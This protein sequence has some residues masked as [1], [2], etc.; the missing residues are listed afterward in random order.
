MI[1]SSFAIRQLDHLNRIKKH[2]WVKVL[3]CALWQKNLF[4][5]DVR[6]YHRLSSVYGY[7]VPANGRDAEQAVPADVLHN[8]SAN[9]N[10][11]RLVTAYREHGHNYAQLN[12]LSSDAKKRTLNDLKPSTY[13]LNENEDKLYNIKGILNYGKEAANL[14]EII[15]ILENVYCGSVAA[16]FT[17]LEEVEREWF[18][19][20]F[21]N[22][23]LNELVENSEKITIATEMIKSQVFENFLAT[24]FGTVKRYSGEGAESSMAFFSRFFTTAPKFGIEQ[25]VMCM[26]HRGRLSL[27]TGMLQYPTINMFRKMKGFS[28]FPDNSGSTGDVLSHLTSSCNLITKDG[29]TLHVTMIPNPSHLEAANP[30]A[31][32]KTR[33]KLLMLQD[34]GYALKLNSNP[35]ILCLQVHGDAAFE[36]QGI[37]MET[38][39]LAN[40]PHFTVEGSVHLTINNQLGFTTPAE[41]GRSSNY[42][43]DVALMIK[44]PIVH[45]NGDYPEEVAKVAG[46]ALEY[47]TKFHKDFFID[48]LCFRRWGHNEL[49][50]PT[51]TNPQMYSV[52]NTRQSVPDLYANKITEDGV[53][54]SDSIN[55]II[56]DYNKELTDFHSQIDNY[57]PN[58]TYRL[59]SW[60][61]MVA[62]GQDITVWDTGID[63]DLL[64]FVGAKSVEIP[65]N[66]NLHQHLHKTHVQ[67]RLNK[68]TEGANIDWATAESLAIGSLLYQGYNVRLSGQ[69]VGRG[70]FSHRHAMLVD[71]KTGDQ[72]IPLNHI[73]PDQKGQFEVANS[74]LS[75][76][77]VLGFEY[78]LS[79]ENPNNLVIW[80]AQFGDFFN[81]AQ[82][83]IDVFVTSGESKWLLQSGMVMMLP[84]GYDGA[85]PEHSSCR[86]ERFLQQC[87]SKENGVDGDNIN[88]QIVH[89]TTS[90]QYFHLLRRQM[91]RN[92]RKPLIIISPKILLRMTAASSSLSDMSPGTTFQ[93][94]IGDQS[95]EPSQVSKVILC[96]GKHY[97]ALNKMRET[98]KKTDTAIVR[99]EELCPF[100]TKLLQNEL[101]K[102][103]KAKTF[104]WSQEEP[105][106]MGP[107]TFVSSRFQNLVGYQL[108]YVGRQ[109]LSV[110]AV[111]IGK[112]HQAEANYVV[113][114]PFEIA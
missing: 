45:V 79:I 7:F 111:G 50:D 55:K 49:D 63:V 56:G 41:R 89:P 64:K 35:K 66:F 15:A 58:Q 60:K 59:G 17:H 62:P 114:Q 74:I 25:V 6:H 19:E 99:L 105:Q 54:S 100:P 86:M 69:D 44:A 3:N 29:N 47:R 88:I 43:T 4:T 92:F 104:I 52:I 90:A 68:L 82:I 87:D 34:G 57:K 101:G 28:E 107:W 97:Y 26:P 40:A 98:L 76:E 77:A 91:V 65:N 22:M 67:N 31:V 53:M 16:E 75:E 85:G 27:L 5:N 13:S 109:A 1:R 21:E 84:H 83:I 102:Y 14:K 94:V 24:K 72:H 11:Y 93:S 70:T 46:L 18:A 10:L 96:C 61:D 38:L 73:V 113:S 36:A 20:K 32:G 108:I 103:T 110:P 51:F 33:G 71:Q 112:I 37:C 95:V 39:A 42:T 8:R 78:G 23:K 30:V 9:A 12:P 80:E 2:N 81:G 48:L 106:N